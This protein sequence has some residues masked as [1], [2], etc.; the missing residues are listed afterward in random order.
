MIESPLRL[1]LV[2]TVALINELMDRFEHSVFA[3][4]QTAVKD[5]DDIIT[6]RHYQGNWVTCSGLCNE[7]IS[8]INNEREDKEEDDD[9]PL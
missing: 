9:N 3:G 6:Q 1:E 7:I 2:P 5:K 4:I 8:V